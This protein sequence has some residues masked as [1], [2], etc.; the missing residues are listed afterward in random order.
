MKTVVV[1]LDGANWEHLEP[2]IEGGELPNLKMLKQRGAW[3]RSASE[4]P[5]VT[6]PNW[7]CYSTG[8]NPGKL[9]VFW[10]ELVD[11]ANRS[12]SMPNSR[13]FDGAELFD[14]LSAA[15]LRC[16]VINM[17]TTYPPRHLD[18]GF[19]IAGGPGCA[20]RGYTAPT[21]LE[22]EL[23]DRFGYCTH[24]GIATSK[25]KRY[26]QKVLDLIDLRFEAGKYLM[27]RVDFLQITVFYINMLQHFFWKDDP[28]LEGWRRIDRHLGD[29]MARDC[30]LVL[31]S[32]H[33]C[34]RIDRIFNINAWLVEKGYLV[35]MKDFS[36]DRVPIG[37]KRLISRLR[38]NPA[39]RSRVRRWLPPQLLNRIGL[40]QEELRGSLKFQMIDWD[41]TVA[42]A[43]GQGPVYLN[44]GSPRFRSGLDEELADRLESLRDPSIDRPPVLR[45]H[46]RD[47]VYRGDYLYRA[48]D[49][50]AEQNEGFYIN[51]RVGK[52]ILFEPTDLWQAENSRLGIFL[53]YGP[54]VA[55]G[56][57]GETKITDIA[58]TL[59]RWHGLPV[60][61]DMDGLA[62]SRFFENAFSLQE[63]QISPPG[64]EQRPAQT[65]EN[66]DDDE[67]IIRRQLINLGYMEEG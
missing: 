49:L 61:A 14:Y 13:S 58:P 35:L 50:V 33:G 24:P 17:P 52:T 51:G 46:R 20:D 8:K 32:D 64:L 48:P 55:P 40:L 44:P 22:K 19:M 43:S 25:R 63:K 41:Q 9:G 10:W 54:G 18:G 6:F 57:K 26:I 59:L 12:V 37:L 28:V 31:L 2:W 67:E 66:S 34:C 30:R 47:E 53:M 62:R 5:Y 60:P 11:V 29:F 7:K 27:D 45:V 16:G 36:S 3:S 15:G 4:L 65:F 1:G 38:R 42:F 56:F 39:L 21:E 23:T